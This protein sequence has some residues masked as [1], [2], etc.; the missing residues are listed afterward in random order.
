M[1]DG[2]T[3]GA[4]FFVAI[5]IVGHASAKHKLLKAVA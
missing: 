1:Q 4:I 5:R 2:S 3:F